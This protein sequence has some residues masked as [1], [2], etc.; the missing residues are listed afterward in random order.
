MNKPPKYLHITLI[1][2]LL[3]TACAYVAFLYSKKATTQTLSIDNRVVIYHKTEC[4]YC[5]KAKE[6][7]DSINI[8]YQEIDITW[9]PEEREAL[10]NTTGIKTV[11]YIFI[12]DHYIGG[13][14][15]L[16]KLVDEQKLTTHS[17]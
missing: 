2:F 6:L 9:N 16:K 4:I 7:L 14:T 17:N 5:I 13:Y 3:A 11:P 10:I 12:N 1:F 8:K 15:D